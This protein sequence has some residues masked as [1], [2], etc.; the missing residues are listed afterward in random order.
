MKLP[1]TISLVIL[2]LLLLTALFV[3]LQG[4]NPALLS[5]EDASPSLMPRQHS[6]FEELSS[7]HK[8]LVL[9]PP[10]PGVS[11]EEEEAYLEELSEVAIESPYIDVTDCMPSPAVLRLHTGQRFSLQSHDTVS[12]TITFGEGTTVNVP[13]EG[14]APIT[15]NYRN[16]GFYRYGC[17]GKTAPALLLI[18]AD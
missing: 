5:E 16:P 1:L 10:P 4:N 6:S 2:V 8:E 7:A 17:D 14:V 13:A 9:L 12:R 15:L 3:L 11:Q 18:V